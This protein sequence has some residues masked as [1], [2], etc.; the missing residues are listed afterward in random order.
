M[1]N[2]AK[3]R[4]FPPNSDRIVW[5]VY[6]ISTIKDRVHLDMR[7]RK[8]KDIIERN[9]NVMRRDWL[10]Q[11]AWKKRGFRM[12]KWS[13]TAV[14]IG[15][16]DC[17]AECWIWSVCRDSSALLGYRK[18]TSGICAYGAAGFRGKSLTFLRSGSSVFSQYDALLWRKSG[19]N[20]KNMI[21]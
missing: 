3:K 20:G 19:T 1:R 15:L 11:C 4:T 14:G 21:Y 5:E 10:E 18:P 2:T 8:I 16:F 9:W 13:E 17:A 6:T 12:A 7:N